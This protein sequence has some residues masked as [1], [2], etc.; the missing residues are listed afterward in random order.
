MIATEIDLETLRLDVLGFADEGLGVELHDRQK[1]IIR[2]IFPVGCPPET[3]PYK[4][5]HLAT[6]NRFGKSVIIAVVQMW[7]AVF[8]HRAPL[9][10]ASSDWFLF[11][12]AAVNV[13]PQN[14]NA[15]V[16]REKVGLILQD[17]AKE[18]IMRPSGRGHIHPAIQSMFKQAR[19]RQDLD[20]SGNPFLLMIPD[21]DYKGYLT[22]HNVYLEY[23]TVDA[24]ARALQGRTKYLVTFDEA[25]RY[26]DCVTL[27][28]SDVMPRTIDS[29]GIVITATTPHLETESDYEEVWERGNPS[30]PDRSPYQISFA[31][32]MKDNPHVAQEMI[33]EAM[34]GQPGYLYDQIVN[35]KFVQS[36]EAFF[37][38][39]S[40]EE[41]GD[42]D[43]P[44]LRRRTRNHTYVLSWDLAVAK[45]G[46]RCI[47]H[48]WDVTTLP[49]I[50]TEVLELPKGT[51]QDAIEREMWEVLAFYNEE[52]WGNTGIMTFDET[53]MGGRMFRDA[54]AGFRPRPKP[55][56]FAGN[57][58]KKLG[59]L[60]NSKMFFDKRL[61]KYP[62]SATRFAYEHKR[63]RRKDDKDETDH[64]M[65]NAMA[66]Y[67]AS[68][69]LLPAK[70]V[71][72]I[73]TP[74]IV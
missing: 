61:I 50:L 8:K 70:N 6:G 22:E 12:Y 13:G 43:L 25:G 57:R 10:Y 33:D 1:E 19:S 35:G 65:A 34:D 56:N 29:R 71:H 48:V 69:M 30:N 60:K 45:D 21:T 24:G 2:A 17:Q 20:K 42:P 38:A 7:F 47:C 55:F 15:Y 58:N 23:R 3:W 52:R 68:R 46:D 67:W 41:A 27:I 39:K 59:I 63:Y 31:A 72:L 32:S 74:V 5:A 66:A 4:S 11:P 9:P 62:K 26:R 64:V 16:V 36:E 18:Q 54:I 51:K 44:N 37:N 73:T 53:G 49:V 28:A 14:E 40:I